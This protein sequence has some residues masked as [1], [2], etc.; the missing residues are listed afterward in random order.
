M[1]GSKG[2]STSCTGV[3]PYTRRLA[4]LPTLESGRSGRAR[5]D[6][7]GGAGKE[8]VFSAGVTGSDGTT[9]GMAA[10][11]GEGEGVDTCTGGV[12]KAERALFGVRGGKGGGSAFELLEATERRCCISLMACS[13]ASKSSSMGE[14]GSALDAKG[15]SSWP[16]SDGSDGAGAGAGFRRIFLSFLSVS[17]LVSSMSSVFLSFVSCGRRRRRRRVV[18]VVHRAQRTLSANGRDKLCDKYE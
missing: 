12:G 14:I 9:V 10:G 11:P 13:T 17:W 8:C 1:V 18:S 2:G 3:R 16:S 6:G 5:L 15:S 7:V 4:A